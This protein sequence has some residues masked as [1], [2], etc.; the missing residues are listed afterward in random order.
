MQS[1]VQIS[2]LV[3]KKTESETVSCSW[4]YKRTLKT[5]LYAPSKNVTTQEVTTN[6]KHKQMIDGGDS[7][8]WK[9]A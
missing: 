8:V 3:T 4:W 6:T 5:D 1:R 2:M 9:W 7:L